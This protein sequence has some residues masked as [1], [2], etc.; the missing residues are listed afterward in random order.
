MQ[1]LGWKQLFEQ[2]IYFY[3]FCEIVGQL[4]VDLKWLF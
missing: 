3:H 4:K 2:I 1:Y